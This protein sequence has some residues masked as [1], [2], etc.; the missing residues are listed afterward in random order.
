ML[1]LQIDFR[2]LIIPSCLFVNVELTSQCSDFS[3]FTIS[4]IMLDSSRA[5]KFPP[6]LKILSTSAITDLILH[7]HKHIRV[8]VITYAKL[9]N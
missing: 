9:I 5:I 8:H 1:G 7:L 6:G 4:I 3:N 2:P